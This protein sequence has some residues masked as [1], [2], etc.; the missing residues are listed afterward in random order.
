MRL[1]PSLNLNKTLIK[2]VLKE[3]ES[4]GRPIYVGSLAGVA[5]THIV[6]FSL[7]YYIDNT[8]VGFFTLALTLCSPLLIIPSVLGTTLFKSF[9]NL[10]FI[11]KKIFI[12]SIIATF[13][14]LIIFYLIIDKIFLFFYSEEFSPV[15]NISK[16][17]IIGFMLHGLGD[18][19]NRFLGAKGQGNLLR[20]AAFVVGLV[21][22]L[23]YS[24]LVYYFGTSGA[25]A[26]KILASGVYLLMMIY[27]YKKF[28]K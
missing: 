3:N 5:T 8:Q 2:K 18:L 9:T 22:I 26:T 12:F 15:I 7:S 21:N 6:G 17:L 4:N 11:P 27:Y 28:I 23:G 20:N 10:G 19:I 16:I 13:V 24:I 14:A 1:R 25:I